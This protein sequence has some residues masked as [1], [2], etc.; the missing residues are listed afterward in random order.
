M[1]KIVLDILMF[2]MAGVCLAQDKTPFMGNLYNKEYDVFL[3]INFYDNNIKIPHQPIFGDVPGYLEYGKDSRAWIVVSA[4]LIG[5]DKARLEISNDYG[6]EDLEATL[7]VGKNG[8]YKL[9]QGKG[10]HIKIA[11][12]RKWVKIPN[13]L[14]FIRVE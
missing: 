3:H 7:T 2:L 6:S 4:K 8:E 5:E 13:E 9:K 11:V 10:S 12:N 1:K 14:V